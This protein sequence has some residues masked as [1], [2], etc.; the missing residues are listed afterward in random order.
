MAD[1]ETI[2]RA[3]DLVEEQMQEPIGVAEMAAA[4]GYSLWH[5]C[6]TFGAAAHVT[7]YDYLMRRRLAEAA[8]AL[9]RTERRIIDVALD[10]QFN[11]P[12]TFSRAFKRVLGQQPSRWRQEGYLDPRRVMPRLTLAHL[13]HMDRGP[14][15]KAQL[16][17]LDGL[18]LAG[19][20]TPDGAD[21]GAVRRA[22]SLL[23]AEPAAA[24][25]GGYY[26]LACHGQAP[27]APLYYLAAVEIE[28]G[29]G[30]AGPPALVS[31]QVPAGRWARFVHKG[32]RDALP[33]TMDYV[34][35]LW[36][37]QSG[38]SLARPWVLEQYG[39]C[40]PDLDDAEAE[41]G[42]LV[43]LGQRMKNAYPIP[44]AG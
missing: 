28:A 20:M 6:R 26:G 31:K 39:A 35:H 37:P 17:T 32:P 15:L 36:L 24:T 42:I 27:G 11:N 8:G 21:E 18:R 23:A 30:A 33:L 5:F 16:V 19:L 3:L 10:Y 14:Y 22:W 2:A 34:Y 13:R 29:E 44:S 9:L 43:P 25:V 12:E 1:L 38:H 40:L 4:A 41:T 7:P